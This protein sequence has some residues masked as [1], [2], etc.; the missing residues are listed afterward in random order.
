MMVFTTFQQ[1]YGGDTSLLQL[2]T[3]YYHYY[4]HSARES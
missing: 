3:A 2:I 1:P 4:T